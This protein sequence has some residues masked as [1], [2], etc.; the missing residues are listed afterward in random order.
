MP[1][2]LLSFCRQAEEEAPRRFDLYFPRVN[3]YLVL[4]VPRHDRPES[5]LARP[6]LLNPV[7]SIT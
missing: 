4:L 1:G 7:G 2:K 6:L 5:G 3:R